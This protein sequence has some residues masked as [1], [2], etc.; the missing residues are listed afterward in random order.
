[1]D[2]GANARR[3]FRGERHFLAFDCDGV[4]LDAAGDLLKDSGGD[5]GD[6]GEAEVGVAELLV[7]F[8]RCSWKSW[9]TL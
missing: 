8:W 2:G 5:A 1:M 3:V 7:R 9:L 6:F 4:A